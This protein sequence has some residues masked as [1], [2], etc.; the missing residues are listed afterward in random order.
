MDERPPSRPT[1]PPRD[2]DALDET[3]PHAGDDADWVDVEPA[4]E[5]TPE[6][7][8]EQPQL[9]WKGLMIGALISV[10]VWLVLAAAAYALF[11]LLAG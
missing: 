11:G 1:T 5:P 3:D 7:E 10:G 9:F 8:L 2:P 6:P 4:T